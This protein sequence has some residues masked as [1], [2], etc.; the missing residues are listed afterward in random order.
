MMFRT[1]LGYINQEP[2][3]DFLLAQWQNSALRLAL[4][5]PGGTSFREMAPKAV[6]Y[7]GRGVRE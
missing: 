6:Q 3:I 5:R 1:F 2:P 7:R 4:C